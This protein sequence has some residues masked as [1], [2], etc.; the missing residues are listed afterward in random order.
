MALKSSRTMLGEGPHNESVNLHEGLERGPAF[1]R[2]PP[3]V[4]EFEGQGVLH[5]LRTSRD[6]I[7]P[8][9]LLDSSSTSFIVLGRS[10]ILRCIGV[11]R[12]SSNTPLVHSDKG[13]KE[14]TFR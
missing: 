12:S 1:R 10:N 8:N 13:Q 3:S 7:S 5:L 6:T 11:Q 9:G 4:V 2:D 14:G